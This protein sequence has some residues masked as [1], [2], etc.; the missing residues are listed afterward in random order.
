MKLDKTNM[1][2]PFLMAMHTELIMIIMENFKY[3]L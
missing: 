3:Q 1:E 2:K